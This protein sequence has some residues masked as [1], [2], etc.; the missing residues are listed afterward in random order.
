[1]GGDRLEENVG[2]RRGLAAG[3]V[4]MLNES[5]SERNGKV[6]GAVRRGSRKRDSNE[7]E[8]RRT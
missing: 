4:G 7:I 5:G 2:E 6:E 1:M 3:V 8:A